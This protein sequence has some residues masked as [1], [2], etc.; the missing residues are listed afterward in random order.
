MGEPGAGNRTGV[1]EGIAVDVVGSVATVT[2]G[3]GERLNAL[4]M[5][6]WEAL[7]Q[8]ARELAGDES[9][10]AVVVRG[11]GGV[12]SA[13]SDLREWEGADPEEVTRRFRRMEEAFR[14]IE[15]LPMPTVAVVEGVAAGGGFQLAL[16]CDLQL[17]AESARVGMPIS[18]LGILVPPSFATRLSLRIG[19]ART[20]E[21]LFGGRMLSAREAHAVGLITTAVDDA[22]LELALAGLL[23]SWAGL[24]HRSLR[25]AKAAVDLGLA[26]LVGPVRGTPLELA[27]DPDEF[28]RRVSE[29]LHRRSP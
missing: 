16:A 10:R 9:V 17:A 28:P 23:D 22:G 27:A 21:L 4:G 29:F 12:F 13:G 2:F 18:R 24:S 15:D 25:A 5:G 11:R 3:S 19:P 6:Q 26:P 7:G 8:A 1:M 14:A 20:K